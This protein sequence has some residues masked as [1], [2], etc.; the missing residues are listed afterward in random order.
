MLESDAIEK[1][2]GMKAC[3][4]L[5]DIV[6]RTDIRV[7]ER[8]GSLCFELETGEDLRFKCDF[9]RKELQR[10]ESVQAGV[11]VVGNAHATTAEFFDDP[12]V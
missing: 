10:D 1:F 9:R 4:L 5:T 3:I 2:H 8:G 11:F 12:V 7:I 6:N